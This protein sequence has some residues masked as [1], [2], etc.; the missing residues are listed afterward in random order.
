[1]SRTS[2]NLARLDDRIAAACA[3]FGEAWSEQ[4]R[5]AAERAL[6][7]GAP[8]DATEAMRRLGYLPKPER[9]IP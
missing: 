3:A 9:R 5:V 8:A 7:A 4:L 2:E 6:A 1:M